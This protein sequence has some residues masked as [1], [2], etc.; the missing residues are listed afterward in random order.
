MLS[1]SSFLETTSYH[2]TLD[3]HVTPSISMLC[4]THTVTVSSEP[5][6]CGTASLPL[7]SLSSSRKCFIFMI[8][9]KIRI[10][11]STKPDGR[12][13]PRIRSEHREASLSQQKNFFRSAI[14]NLPTSSFTFKF[15]VRFVP[16]SSEKCP[17]LSPRTHALWD[18][19]LSA[20]TNT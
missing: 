16:Q 13:R 17:L 5:C 11:L 7:L 6:R 8:T 19:R 9:P 10:K 18:Q 15:G 2:V 4:H 3:Y 20:Y 1:R 14:P 12:E